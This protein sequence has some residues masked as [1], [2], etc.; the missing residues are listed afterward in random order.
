MRGNDGSAWYVRQEQS[1]VYMFGEHPGKKYATIFEGTIDSHEINGKYWDCPK[2]ERTFKGILVLRIEEHGV[3]LVVQSKS[4]GIDLSELKSYAI[5]N[6]QLP[7]AYRKPGFSST[8]KEDLDGAWRSGDMNFYVREVDN[9]IVGWVEQS[10]A[11]GQKPVVARI[12]L[13]SRQADGR[14]AFQLISL[15]KGQANTKT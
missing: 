3:K 2:G 13:G 12:A 1:K 6:A 4:G 7:T 10:F 8:S 11:T 9:R 14:I 15:P 5:E